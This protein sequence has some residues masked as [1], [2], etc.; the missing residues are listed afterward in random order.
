M[1]QIAPS[2]VSAYL[3]NL[4]DVINILEEAGAN[5]IHFDVEDG[6]FVPLMTLGTKIIRD[7]R[8][9]TDLPFDVHLM[10]WEPEWLVAQVAEAGA[11]WISIHYEACKYPRRVLRYIKQLGRRAG[12][13]FNPKTPLPDLTYLFPYLDLVVILTTEPEFPDQ[14][15]LPPM[16]E[17]VRRASRMVKSVGIEVEVD[18][19]ITPSNAAAVIDAG[20]TI[21]VSGRGIF[22]GGNIVSNLTKFKEIVGSYGISHNL[23]EKKC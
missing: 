4:E 7:L 2:L 12:I 11:D 10:V 1:V 14:E 6:N 13:A 8:G 22:K 3:G 5:F 15:Y 23:V 18:G 20:G 19:G 17:K 9:Y 16:L 21:L